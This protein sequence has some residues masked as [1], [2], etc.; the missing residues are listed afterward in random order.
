MGGREDGKGRREGGME[1]GRE[2]EGDRGL[3]GGREERREG[4]K[5]V[6][7]GVWWKVKKERGREGILK[8]LLPT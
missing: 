8:E 1:G 7:E 5:S 2:W 3:E 6:K 4:D